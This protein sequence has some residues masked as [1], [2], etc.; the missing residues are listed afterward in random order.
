MCSVDLNMGPI[1][2]TTYIKMVFSFLPDI[3]NHFTGNTLWTSDDSVMQLIHIFHFFMINSVLYK[4]HKK[5]SRGN[6]SGEGGSQ[7]MGLLSS[8]PMLRKL[9]V[10]KGN[11]MGEGKWCTN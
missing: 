8:Y 1:S 4:P 10:Q 5:K 9:P 2:G 7:G 6:K 3:G 11:M